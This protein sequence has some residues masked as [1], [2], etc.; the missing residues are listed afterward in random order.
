ME[1][2]ALCG[3]LYGAVAEL[4]ARIR[5]RATLDGIGIPDRFIPQAKQSEQQAEC[6]LDVEGIRKSLKKVFGE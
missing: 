6:G 3:G 2:G 4:L 1:D 5:S